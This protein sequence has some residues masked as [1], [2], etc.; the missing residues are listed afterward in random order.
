MH[1]IQIF[2]E[3]SPVSSVVSSP[4]RLT[5]CLVQGDFPDGNGRTHFIHCSFQHGLRFFRLFLTE[6]I[7]T[8]LFGI[9]IWFLLPDCE[10]HFTLMRRILH[11]NQSLREFFY[12]SRDSKMVN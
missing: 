3:I 8:V 6:G 5:L 11:P 2:V 7:A 10:T 1:D 4:T 9:A 12:S